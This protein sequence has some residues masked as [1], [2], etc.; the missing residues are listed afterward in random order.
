M[1]MQ[2]ATK[3]YLM[4]SLLIFVLS[5]ALINSLQAQTDC[6]CCD[7]PHK[8]FD[9]WVGEWIVLDSLGE[10]VG[11]SQISHIEDHCILLE[12]WKGVTGVTGSSFNYYNQSDSTWNQLWI[13]NGGNILELKGQAGP[14][15]MILKST[16]QKGTHIDWYYNQITWTLHKD[17][18]VSQLWEIFDKKDVLLQISFLGI[19]H[20]KE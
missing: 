10:K 18:T 20:R 17:G 1:R 5:Y 7:E 16:L 13:D 14:N 15:K 2:Y 6:S 9:F 12:H 8:Q 4:K 19:Y 11:D 3:D